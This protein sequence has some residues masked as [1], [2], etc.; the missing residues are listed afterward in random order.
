METDRQLSGER[1]A[2]EQQ[3]NADEIRSHESPLSLSYACAIRESE[4]KRF[5]FY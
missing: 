4:H 3:V 2:V 5:L 1:L